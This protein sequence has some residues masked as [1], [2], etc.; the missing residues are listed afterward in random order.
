MDVEVFFALHTVVYCCQNIRDGERVECSAGD[1]D[2]MIESRMPDEQTRHTGTIKV[3]FGFSEKLSEDLDQQIT[4]ILDQF[5]NKFRPELDF[6]CCFFDNIALETLAATGTNRVW[7]IQLS[8]FNF[9]ETAF[10][11]KF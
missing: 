7:C 6:I 5:A 11:I 10:L 3:L 1:D 8:L 9:I 4:H 2:S